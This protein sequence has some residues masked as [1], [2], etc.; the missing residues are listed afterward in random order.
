MGSHIV[1][2]IGLAPEVVAHIKKILHIPLT[3]HVHV[4]IYSCFDID[5]KRKDLSGSTNLKSYVVGVLPGCSRVGLSLLCWHNFEA[6]KRIGNSSG[7][8]KAVE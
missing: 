4:H 8:I 2:D 3:V 7:I 6:C 5:S 1:L